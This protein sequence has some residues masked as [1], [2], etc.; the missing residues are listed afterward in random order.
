MPEPNAR[1]RTVLTAPRVEFDLSALVLGMVGVLLYE[2]YWRLMAPLLG[3]AN[4]VA[5]AVPG[6]EE[7]PHVAG[8]AALRS[9]LFTL[10]WDLLGRLAPLGQGLQWIGWSPIAIPG[11]TPGAAPDLYPLDL[12]LWKH[13]V[14]AGGLLL[15]WS[16]IGG[17]IARVYAVRIGRDESIPFDD[18]LA[19][20]LRNLKSFLMAPLFIAAAAVFFVALTAAVGAVAAIPTAGGVLQA[21]LHPLALLSGLIVTI[22]AIGGLFGLPVLHAAL[23]T[24]RNGTLD[25]ISRTF[26]YLF[27]RPVTF[28]V[29]V[30]V[31]VV[32][33]G[34]ISTFGM[35]FLNFVTLGS[36]SLGAAWSDTAPGLLQDAHT[37]AVLGQFPGDLTSLSTGATITVWVTWFWTSVGALLVRGFVLAYAV[38]GLTDLYFLMR[39]EV[40]GTPA[41]Q[42]HVDGEPELDLGDPVPGQPTE[43]AFD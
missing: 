14:A 30:V 37:V 8:H 18:G 2:V 10:I 26:S 6:V 43:P 19:F 15:L 34:V 11:A 16:V 13:A 39:R 29:G 31:I 3:V 23:A 33:S 5:L 40:D 20:S 21:L 17:A 25:A 41:S 9:E 7:A 12:P 1:S 42:V 27:T 4:E 22:I 35:W 32:V 38:G 36:L 28:I 24:E